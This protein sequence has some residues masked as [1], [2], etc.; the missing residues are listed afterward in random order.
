MSQT[1]EIWL[2]LSEKLR[3]FIYHKVADREAAEDILQ[4]LFLRIHLKIDTLKDQTRLKPWLYQVARNL[5]NDYFRDIKQRRGAM[6][7][8]P[9]IEDTEN[10]QSVMETAVNDM[11]GMMK[12]LSTASCEALCMTEIEGLSQAEFAK[13]A[14][15][16]YS[17]AKSRVQ[18]SKKLLRDMLMKCCHYN[19]DKYGT[20]LSISPKHCCCCNPA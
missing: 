1:E 5:I 3:A 19:F 10:D 4:E 2:N 7:A 20:V 11:I 16:P 14:G 15:I 8:P 18:R 9:G 12:E 6:D 17:S 13:K